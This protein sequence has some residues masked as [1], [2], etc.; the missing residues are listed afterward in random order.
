MFAMAGKLT[1]DPSIH[2]ELVAILRTLNSTSPGETGCVSYAF[3][4]D[5]DDP[6][7][8]RFFECWE[9]QATFD[10]HCATPH[11]TTFME[12]CMPK[13]TAA[14]AARYEIIEMTKLV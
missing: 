8:V 2:D 14:E 4:V 5:I 10:A 9:D 11:Y 12:Q 13:V 1:F 6:N 7:T 3:T